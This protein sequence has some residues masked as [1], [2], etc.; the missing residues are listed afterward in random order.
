MFPMKQVPLEEVDSF[1][2]MDTYEPIH[3]LNDDCLRYIFKWLPIVDRIRLER[4]CRRWRVVSEESWHDFKQLDFVN[5]S[6]G[7]KRPSR[8]KHVTIKILKKI[9][10]RCGQHLIDIEFAESHEKLGPFVFK[11]IANY[12]PNIQNIYAPNL[13]ISPSS[14]KVL[15]TK[16][17][18]ISSFA[19]GDCTS[20]C[21]S[22]LSL[23]FENNRQ[24]KE[25][26]IYSNFEITGKCLSKLNHDSIET[27]VFE[28]CPAIKLNNF[29][30]I[31]TF[32]NLKEFSI[33]HFHDSNNKAIENISLCENLHSLTLA[34]CPFYFNSLN[35]L[36]KLTNLETL[37]LSSNISVNDE[38][39]KGIGGNCKM[40][41]N[42]DLS[43]CLAVTNSGLSKIVSLPRL[44]SLIIGDLDGVT[45]EV[46][47]N[48]T[49][50]NI[51]LL[52][53][54]FCPNIRDSGLIK[55]IESSPNIEYLIVNN[56]SGITKYLISSAMNIKHQRGDDILLKIRV[57]NTKIR[58]SEVRGITP[59]LKALPAIVLSAGCGDG[60]MM[61]NIMF[62][63]AEDL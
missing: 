26:Y 44:R 25:L 35:R 34:L 31:K 17:N 9:L 41:K 15:A 38:I 54:S 33:E 2:S 28:N 10:R 13:D 24:L 3:N 12:C 46:F 1:P 21:D 62:D 18:K 63:E 39:L 57:G 37:D 29:K 49:M 23:L 40:L 42:V 55:L 20:P 53:C 8:M 56:C 5:E 36:S 4:V 30:V 43:Y 52:D 32:K 16:C 22:E 7:F 14:I 50:P 59:N 48:I 61:D 58:M 11:T 45:D 47:E 6:W 60:I 19:I 27:I 51:K